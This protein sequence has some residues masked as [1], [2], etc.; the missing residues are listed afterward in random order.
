L[1][2]GALIVAAFTLGATEVPLLV[3]PTEP[4]TIATYALT[5]VHTDGPV[6]RARATAALVIVTAI[7][8][9]LGAL[10]AIVHRRRTATR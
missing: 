4:D 2:A 7:A 10:A 8:L 1:A 5:A 6:A 9:T 3:G